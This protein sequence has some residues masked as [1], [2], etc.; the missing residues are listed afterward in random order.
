MTNEPEGSFAEVHLEKAFAQK[1]FNLTVS[2]VI[3]SLGI[4]IQCLTEFPQFALE[5]AAIF[6]FHRQQTAF[7]V[8]NTGTEHLCS[9]LCVRGSTQRG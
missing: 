2:N 7:H 5:N 9:F 1:S 8:S 4:R 6:C 3:P